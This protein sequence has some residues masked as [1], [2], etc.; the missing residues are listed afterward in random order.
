MAEPRIRAL[1]AHQLPR[2]R[3][4]CKHL[5]ADTRQNR[6]E[7]AALEP[8]HDRRIAVY[9]VARRNCRGI[10]RERR[11]SA[12]SLEVGDAA[13]DHCGENNENGHD[14][15]PD[16]SHLSVRLRAVSRDNLDRLYPTRPQ[17]REHGVAALGLH[18]CLVPRPVARLV[19]VGVFHRTP[20]RAVRECA[21]IPT[22]LL[23]MAGVTG[24]RGKDSA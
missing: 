24:M 17:S 21:T 2:L 18:R 1:G 10:R 6:R 3:E 16:T 19:C 5:V 22:D 20:L 8:L 12:R 13:N 11:A 14:A 4:N 7:V 9:L 23:L 15:P